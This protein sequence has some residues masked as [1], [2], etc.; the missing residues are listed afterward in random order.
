MGV[1]AAPILLYSKYS[2]FQI[3]IINLIKQTAKNVSEVAIMQ[4]F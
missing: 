1:R 2:S 3:I 4:A